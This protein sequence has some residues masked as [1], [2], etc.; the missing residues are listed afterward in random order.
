MNWEQTDD[1]Q[2]V[3]KESENEFQVLNVYEYPLEDEN[4]SEQFI[5]AIH[6]VDLEFETEESLL[7]EIKPFGYKTLQEVED[8]YGDAKNQIL[9]E[10]ISENLGF[11]NGEK[12]TKEE[13]IMYLNTQQNIIV[14]L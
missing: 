13:L 14:Q 5:V 1:F 11:E 10:C 9:A 2:W 8:I 4:D 6:I 3:K 7:E 12:M